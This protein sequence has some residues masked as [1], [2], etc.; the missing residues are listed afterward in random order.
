MLFHT[1]QYNKPNITVPSGVMT[2][3]E[4]TVT[5]TMTVVEE[6]LSDLPVTELAV[7]DDPSDLPVTG[8]PVVEELPELQVTEL[9]VV[10]ELP[11]TGLPVVEELPELQVTELAVV[12][13]PSDLPVTGLVGVELG[14]TSALG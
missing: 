3:T 9:A 12:D 2:I 4:V 14:G 8:L 5:D 6:E 11:V 10:E 7:V 1:W 13:D